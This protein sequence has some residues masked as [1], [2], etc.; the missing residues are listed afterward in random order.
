MK[1]TKEEKQVYRIGI[2][3]RLFGTAMAVGI[4]R[5]TEELIRHLIE[6]DKDNQYYI[7]LS[8]SAATNFPIYSPNLSKTGVDF[9][10]NYYS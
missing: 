2:D 8:K 3:A 9:S 5:Y 6:L 1:I 4:G 7:F 10:N